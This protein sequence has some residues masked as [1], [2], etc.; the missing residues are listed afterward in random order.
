MPNAHFK[1]VKEVDATYLM[2]ENNYQRVLMERIIW[3]GNRTW[4]SRTN[5]NKEV[6][7]NKTYTLGLCR[8]PY[9]LAVQS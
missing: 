1:I 6:G 7:L 8:R 2:Q 4:S 3:Q 5:H 9:G